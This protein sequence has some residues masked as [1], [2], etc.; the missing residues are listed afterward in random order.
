MVQQKSSFCHSFPATFRQEENKRSLFSLIQAIKLL[1]SFAVNLLGIKELFAEFGQRTVLIQ[2]AEK[3]A[4]VAG[5]AGS[6]ADLFHLKDH[7]IFVTVNKDLVNDLHVTG[8][9]ALVPHFLTGT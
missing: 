1:V 3:A 2:L 9:F 6:A 5:M 7:S 8:A 4:G